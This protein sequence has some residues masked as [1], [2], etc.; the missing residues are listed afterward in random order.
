VPGIQLAHAGRKGSHYAPWKSGHQVKR[1]EGGWETVAPSAIPFHEGQE[2]PRALDEAGLKKLVSDFR[3]ATLRALQAGY[4]LVEIHAAHGY[5]L[6]E[7]MSPLCNQRTDD[8]GGSFENRIRLL[9]EITSAVRSVWPSGLPMFVRLSCTDWAEGGWD[10]DQTVQ[11]SIRLKALGVDLI[12]CSSGGAVHHQK[13]HIGPG[14]QV[15]FSERIR[16]EA[17]IATGAVGLITTPEQAEAIVRKE[18]AELVL[19]ARESLRDPHFPLHAAQVL[20]NQ[21]HWPSQ[22]ERAKPV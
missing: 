18:Q 1:S 6:H 21:I 4:E 22:Y 8:H 20:G 15:P 7:F 3:E 9:L 12:D 13:I 2:P 17:G 19:I 5:L 16:R 10:I 11:L 14:Y